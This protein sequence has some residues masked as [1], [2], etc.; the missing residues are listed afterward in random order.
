MSPLAKIL[1]GVVIVFVVF[2]AFAAAAVIYI[3]HRVHEKA[4]EM[5]LI[6]LPNSAE[7]AVRS[8]AALMAAH[9]CRKRMSLRP[10]KWISFAWNRLP[11]IPDV[12]IA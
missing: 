1:I 3:G 6:V 9:C 10:S 8:C 4:A 11:A 2:G 12:L 5:E 7:Q